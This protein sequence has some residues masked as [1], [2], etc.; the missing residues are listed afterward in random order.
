M[1]LD[2]YA[3]NVVPSFA[4]GQRAQSQRIDAERS[5]C[6]APASTRP[7]NSPLAPPYQVYPARVVP[8][9]EERAA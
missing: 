5:I 6:R 8:P 3:L 1:L 2:L 4:A 9:A 7:A